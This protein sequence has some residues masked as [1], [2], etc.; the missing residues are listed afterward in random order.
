WYPLSDV[1]IVGVA[2][3]VRH[4]GIEQAP[5]PCL[6]VAQAQAPSGMASLVIRTSSDPAAAIGAVKEQI[7]KVAPN[8]GIQSVTTMDR[9]IS[10]SLA[11]PK[12]QVTLMV[13]FGSIALVLACVGVFAVVSYSVEQRTREIGVRLAL[14]A[15]LSV[16]LRMILGE[17]LSLAGI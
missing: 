3:D 15:P 10:T 7:R 12:L 14:G 16:I 5:K 17:G 9:L 2:A 1:E 6:F 8:Q 11:R 13:I 4:N